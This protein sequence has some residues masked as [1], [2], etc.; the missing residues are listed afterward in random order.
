MACVR[1]VRAWRATLAVPSDRVRRREEIN[2]RA[3]G[4]DN[5]LSLSA[6][7]LRFAGRSDDRHADVFNGEQRRMEGGG[8]V[9][10]EEEEEGEKRK[11]C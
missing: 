4:S 6:P 5:G 8:V 11:R 9:E 1:G 10:K 3:E 2:G 7:R